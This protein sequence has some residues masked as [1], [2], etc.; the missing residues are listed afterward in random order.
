MVLRN[1]EQV[2]SSFTMQQRC[3]VCGAQFYVEKVH[4]ITVYCIKL[5]FKKFSSL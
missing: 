5:P 2:A 4:S 1:E 3:L